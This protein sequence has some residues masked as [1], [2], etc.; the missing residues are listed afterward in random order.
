MCCSHWEIFI[1]VIRSCVLQPLGSITVICSC[2]LQPLGV[3]HCSH[4]QLCVA[5]IGNYPLQSFAVVLQSLGI[6]HCSHLQ[7]CCSHWELSIAVICSCVAV[8]GNYPLQLPIEALS[9]GVIGTCQS[10]PV[11]FTCTLRTLCWFR[12]GSL[13]MGKG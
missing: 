1:A 3:F 6:I 2:V 10:C 4:L 9:D 13:K 11:C 5:A 12:L 8:I 7:L